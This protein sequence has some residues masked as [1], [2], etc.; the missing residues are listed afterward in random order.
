MGTASQKNGD[1][2]TGET[3]GPY[4]PFY[5]IVFCSINFY[6]NVCCEHISTALQKMR[7]IIGILKKNGFSKNLVFGSQYVLLN[8]M[9]EA[10][11]QQR[12]A[13]FAHMRPAHMHLFMDARPE[14]PQMP[15]SE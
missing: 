13:L 11:Y 12:C 2:S 5:V 1:F 3:N 9:Y 10:P 7:T 6:K 14:T 15:T 4:L 8:L